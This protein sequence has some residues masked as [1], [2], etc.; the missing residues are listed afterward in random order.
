MKI[1]IISFTKKG[2]QLGFSIKD[3]LSYYDVDLYSTKEFLETKIVNE[4]LYIWCKNNFS[5]NNGLIFIGAI[6]IAVRGISPLIKSK[7]QDPAVIVID[8]EGQFIVPILSGHL[9]GA[10]QLA[11]DLAE[12]LN[13]V[14][15]ITTATDVNKVFTVDLFAQKNQCFITDLKKIKEISSSLLEG[16]TI[17]FYSELPIEGNFSKYLVKTDISNENNKKKG[18]SVSFNK[19]QKPFKNTINLVPKWYIVGL[20]CRKG[21]S[22]KALEKFFLSQLN[23]KGI[24]FNC[25]EAVVS[26]DLK[27]EE[28]C[29]LELVEKYN[30][31]FNTYSKEDLKTVEGSFSVSPFVEAITGVD[32]VCERSVVLAGGK[33]IVGK[34]CFEGMTMAIGIYQ[35]RLLF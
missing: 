22:F 4:G 5:N 32:N 25:V 21:I 12:R 7:S 17:G 6:P 2:A 30:L 34:K 20:G 11:R 10:N 15:V 9:G 35:R 14:P 33:L 26:I 28:P 19:N 18:I 16:E 23:N 13:G 29:L 31:K 8:E 24:P 1:S 3:L 27:K